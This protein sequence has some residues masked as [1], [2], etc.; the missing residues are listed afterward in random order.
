M[1]NLCT[2]TYYK[3]PGHVSKRVG[4]FA[5][6][7]FV[8]TVTHTRSSEQLRAEINIEDIVLDFSVHLSLPYL[9]SRI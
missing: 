2:S 6:G 7:Q 5:D 8:K 4:D 3:K 1:N 9:T